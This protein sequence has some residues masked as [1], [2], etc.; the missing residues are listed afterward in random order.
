MAGVLDGSDQ[1]GGGTPLRRL[2]VEAVTKGKTSLPVGE[3]FSGPVKRVQWLDTR[4][5][6]PVSPTISRDLKSNRAFDVRP[7]FILARSP[8]KE[9]VLCIF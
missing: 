3:N 2:L 9:T 8:N 5:V 4:F 6:F 1:E 7:P